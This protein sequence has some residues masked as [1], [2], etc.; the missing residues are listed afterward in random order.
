LE[1]TFSVT[2]GTNFDLPKSLDKLCVLE[3]KKLND[4]RYGLGNAKSD[5]VLIIPRTSPISISDKEYCKKWIK[6]MREQVPGKLLP[7]KTTSCN[8]YLYN[9][10]DVPE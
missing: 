2:N 10:L 8:Y 4:T 6:E 1:I 9:V 3:K 5:V 7:I